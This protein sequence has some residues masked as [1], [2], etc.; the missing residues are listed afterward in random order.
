M[1]LSDAIELYISDHK[2]TYSKSK[3]QV[4]RKIQESSLAQTVCEDITS[5]MLVEFAQ[6]LGEGRATSTLVN[7][8]SHLAPVFRL[9]SPAWDIGLDNSAMIDALAVCKQLSLISKSNRRDRRPTLSELNLLL[10]HFKDSAIWGHM[11]MHKIIVFATFSTRRQDE[12]V[13]FTWE[14]FELRNNRML[15]RDRKNPGQ[16]IGNNVWCELPPE[17]KIVIKSMPKDRSCCPSSTLSRKQFFGIFHSR[18]RPT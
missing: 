16:K 1:T 6:D 13:R 10:S 12:I 3:T 17:A 18:T 7:Y 15:V 2:K 8:L 9:A 5:Q 4:L 14:G 11:P